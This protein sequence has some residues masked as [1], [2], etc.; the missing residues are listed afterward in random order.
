MKMKC[1]VIRWF[2]DKQVVLWSSEWDSRGIRR[3]SKESIAVT[4]GKIKQFGRIHL[5]YFYNSQSVR[6]T[7]SVF[8]LSFV[9]T[10]R[11]FRA[12]LKWSGQ[13]SLQHENTIYSVNLDIKGIPF[14]VYKQSKWRRRKPFQRGK[15]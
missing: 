13:V 5:N 9:R 14:K 2:E 10:S 7:L 1:V 12:R 15:V 6:L 11:K 8:K 3:K 4:V